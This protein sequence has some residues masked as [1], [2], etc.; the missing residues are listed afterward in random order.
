M[1]LFFGCL[2][3]DTLIKAFLIENDLTPLN[4]RKN[5]GMKKERKNAPRDQFF[6]R[7]KLSR[8]IRPS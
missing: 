8:D 5:S 3:L 7:E 6:G 4:A 2:F 1:R